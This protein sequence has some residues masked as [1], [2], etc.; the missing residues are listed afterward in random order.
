MCIAGCFLKFSFKKIETTTDS[1]LDLGRSP[2]GNGSRA[3]SFYIFL[4]NMHACGKL[5]GHNDLVSTIRE[6]CDKQNVSFLK[7]VF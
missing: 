7:Y 6:T 3:R 2:L 5:N 4:M 1:S